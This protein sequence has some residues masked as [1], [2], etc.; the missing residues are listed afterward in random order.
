MQSSRPYIARALYQWLLDNDLTPYIVVDAEQAGVE[1]PRQFVQNGQIVLNLAPTAVRDF[2]MENEAVSFSARFGGRPM[3]VMVP[4][5]ALIA[6]YARENGVGMVFGHEPVIP[7][8]ADE[9][10]EKESH[11]NEVESADD[12]PQEE[13]H[14]DEAPPR[15]GRPSLRV[16]K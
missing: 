1:V 11:L 6:I 9:A 5:E 2:A 13:E 14:G 12:T 7:A 8:E 15:K 4:I 3:Q 10:E 16:I